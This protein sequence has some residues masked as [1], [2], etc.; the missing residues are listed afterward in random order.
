MATIYNTTWWGSPKEIGWG[1]IYYDL[2]ELNE[3]LTDLTFD[4]AINDILAQDPDGDY[5]LVPYGRIQNWDVSQVTYMGY[6]FD[7]RTQF[8][9]DI[10]KWDVSNVTS[11]TRM[12]RDCTKFNQ[13]INEW[14]VS[15]VGSMYLMFS[16]AV[17]FNQPLNYWDV[18]GLSSFNSVLSGATSFNGDVSTW[19]TSNASSF[20]RLFKSNTVFNQDLS[21]WNITGLS[22]VPNAGKEFL[23]AATLSTANYDSLL[24]SWSSQSPITNGILFNFGTSKY[25]LGSAAETAR[26]TLINTNGWTILDGGGI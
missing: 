11:M 14:S 26:N 17:A 24:V 2:K 23:N 13:Y 8:N 15:N 22:L 25:T 12:F 4:Q 20:F 3:P 6:A 19:D 1:S 10:G 5:N 16:N 7:G 9:G 21:G 18:T